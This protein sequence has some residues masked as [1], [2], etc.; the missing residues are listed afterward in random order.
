MSPFVFRF[1]AN[2]PRFVPVSTL[3]FV[4]PHH[5]DELLVEWCVSFPDPAV[6]YMS[7]HVWNNAAPGYRQE[8]TGPDVSDE[9]KDAAAT[10]GISA[11][12]A[13]TPRGDVHHWRAILECP[14]SLIHI[15]EPT[16][17]Y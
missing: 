1:P 13:L 12:D 14:L 15:S 2:D 7:E 17:P 11:P 9:S 10:I 4:C 6:Y 16:R 5:T 3:R 8:F